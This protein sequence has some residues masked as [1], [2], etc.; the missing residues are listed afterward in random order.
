MRGSGFLNEKYPNFAGAPEV[1][2][3]VQKA[4]GDKEREFTPHSQEERIQSYLDRIDY[5]IH[6]E[7]GWRR[8]KYKL[9]KDL[10]INIEDEET[11]TK[12]AHALY[13]SEKRIAKEQGRGADI[14]RLDTMGD[15][16]LQK[17]RG[18]V[19]EKHDIQERTLSSW[20]DY[21]HQNDA[22]YPIWFRYFVLRSLGKMGTLNKE[23]GE[24]GKRSELT[25]APFPELNS[26]ALGFTYRMLTTGI[27]S[28]EYKVADTDDA[29][30]QKEKSDKRNTLL[31]LIEKKDFAKLYAFAQIET[32]GQLNKESLQGDWVKYEQGSDYH[33]LENALRNKGTGWCTA[34]G[35]A[36]AHLEGGDFYVYYTRGT[37]GMYSEPR[38]AIRIENGQVAEVRGVNHRQELEPDLL[39]VATEKYHALPGG[40]KFDKKSA[41]MK[42]M[43]ELMKKHEKSEPLTKADLVF[44]YEIDTKIEGFGYDRDPRIVELR[45][46]R[47]TEEDLLTIFECTKADFAH[48]VSEI[49]DHTKAY[50]GTIEKD[51]FKKLPITC[52]QVYTTFPEGKIERRTLA[53]GGKTPETHIADL[54]TANIYI[55]DYAKDM[56]QN[57]TEYISTITPETHHLVAL[58]VA[59]LGFSNG[60]TTTEIFTKA[61]ELGLS[62]CPHDVGPALCHSYTD[63]PLGEWGRIAMKPIT[64]RDGRPDVFR[65]GRDVGGLWLGSGRAEPDDIW[66]SDD[67]FVFSSGKLDT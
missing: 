54:E 22:Q 53:I 21:L 61:Q 12:I 16:V 50:V 2:R 63:Q 43:T 62:L 35:S 15:K 40:E 37:G 46:N 27:G 66:S 47:N 5:I 3:A 29:L 64:D 14:E 45:E 51:L 30:V 38:V 39:D 4:E 1:Q 28:E 56:L 11:V 44:L 60:A 65:L 20:L 48:H 49:T 59:D 36:H 34:E 67:R 24:Y 7:R 58:T 55:S 6:D 18:A 9:M 26:E 17:Y 41:D 23:K 42:R 33:I 8:L 13:E 57:K 25:I 10:T 32:A 31:A 52:E 19:E